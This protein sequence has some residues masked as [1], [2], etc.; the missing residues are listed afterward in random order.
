M[1][2][3]II[4]EQRESAPKSTDQKR[5]LFWEQCGRCQCSFDPGYRFR[6]KT[7]NE[8]AVVRTEKLEKNETGEKCD[9]AEQQN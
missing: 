9:S 6:S 2:F 7:L 1:C 4:Y 5:L 3:L 8:G